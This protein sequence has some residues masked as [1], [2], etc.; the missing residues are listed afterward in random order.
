[1]ASFPLRSLCWAA[2]S[3][4]VFFSLMGS[5]CALPREASRQACLKAEIGTCL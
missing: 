4:S 2:V 3:F 5:I 1:L